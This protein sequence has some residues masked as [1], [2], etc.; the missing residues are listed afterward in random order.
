MGF[1]I[2]VHKSVNWNLS[3]S[4]SPWSVN[5]N[6]GITGRDRK[7]SSINGSL[8]T[9]SPSFAHAWLT[10]VRLAVTDSIVW[11]DISPAI[12]SPATI[13]FWR[14]YFIYFILKIQYSCYYQQLV[15]IIIVTFNYVW[16]SRYW[17]IDSTNNRQLA[18][19][20]HN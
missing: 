17:L 12:G 15:H 2:Y 9:E 7:V 20:T 11:S 19:S 14:V 3:T 8:M 13:F 6:E 4:I 1:S 18:P 10:L 5:F 16:I